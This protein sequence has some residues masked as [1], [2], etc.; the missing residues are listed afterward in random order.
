[1]TPADGPQGT[2]MY[3]VG[4]VVIVLVALY[5][6]FMALNTAGL[7]EQTASASVSGKAYKEPGKTY[8]TQVI[9]GRS[10]VRPQVTPEAY[11]I[12]V[13]IDGKK[14]TG[15][16]DQSLFEELKE[17]D[18]VKVVYVKQRLTGSIQIL[19]VSR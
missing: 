9:A 18:Q 16:V 3:K 15:Q 11:L 5:G 7:S 13:T 14:A 12:N 10:Y 8:V 2:V 19:R 6:L 4:V 17:G 1:M